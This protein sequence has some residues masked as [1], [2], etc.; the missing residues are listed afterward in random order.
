[1]CP[2]PEVQPSLIGREGEERKGDWSI[3]E[4]PRVSRGGVEKTLHGQAVRIGAE[5]SW[6]SERRFLLRLWRRRVEA[7]VEGKERL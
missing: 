6:R 5:R 1:M 4:V 2:V 7:L 3:K